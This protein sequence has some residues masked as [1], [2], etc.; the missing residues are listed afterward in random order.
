[1]FKQMPAVYPFD[2]FVLALLMVRLNVRIT[3]Y[4]IWIWKWRGE[5]QK[6]PTTETKNDI[7]MQTIWKQ[8]GLRDNEQELQVIIVSVSSKVNEVQ[9]R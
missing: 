8:R 5:C 1:M 6:I 4:H 3:L 2:G 7:S 9:T